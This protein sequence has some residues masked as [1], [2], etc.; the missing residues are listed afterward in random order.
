[1]DI[2]KKNKNKNSKSILVSGRKKKTFYN[3]LDFKVFNNFFSF[4]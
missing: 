3:H 1:M 2:Y 4:L